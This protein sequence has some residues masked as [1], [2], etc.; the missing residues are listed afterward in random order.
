MIRDPS[1]QQTSSDGLTGSQRW[2]VLR[3]VGLA[4]GMTLTLPVYYSSIAAVP[5]LADIVPP[6]VVHSL[7][8]L[9]LLVVYPAT[10]GYAHVLERKAAEQQADQP[11]KYGV[12]D[13]WE[14]RNL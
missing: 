3:M 8:A 9:G 11:P 5:G 13:E 7:M 14:R 2:S 4:V 6:V 1:P 12:N 10:L